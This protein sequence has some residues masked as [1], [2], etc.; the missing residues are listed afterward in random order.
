MSDGISRH[1]GGNPH[2][3]R[4]PSDW[5]LEFSLESKKG[6][7]NHLIGLSCESDPFL[8]RQYRYNSQDNYHMFRLDFR[9]ITDGVRFQA[10]G[11]TAATNQ[12]QTNLSEVPLQFMMS[13][14]SIWQDDIKAT[15]KLL[16]GGDGSEAADMTLLNKIVN[17]DLGARL[18]KL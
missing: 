6:Y 9:K 12:P 11:F 10:G 4:R 5:P 8:L 15:E 1:V 17:P 16:S 2:D 18:V 14:E 3:T 13:D 7:S